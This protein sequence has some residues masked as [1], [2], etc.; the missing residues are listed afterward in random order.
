MATFSDNFSEQLSCPLCLNRFDDPKVLPCLHTFCRRCLEELMRRERATC[1]RCPTCKHEV[2][3]SHDT[4]IDC[5]PS[6]FFI[7]NILDVVV[8]HD[9]D[10]DNGVLDKHP[11]RRRLCTSCDEGSE[12][13]SRCQDCNEYLCDNCVRAHQRV[14]LT[15]DHFIVRLAFDSPKPLPSPSPIQPV[16]DRPPSYCETH[17]KEI[18]RLY[19]DTCSK[20]ICRECTM[21][22]HIGHS[23]IY[24]QDAVESAKTV[25]LKLLADARAGMKA[26]EESIQVRHVQD[27]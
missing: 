6:N 14:R 4:G 23:F 3:L 13:S 10:Y 9:D 12:A 15:K 5:L 21:V 16:S 20:A 8:S 26:I 1:L 7:N 19:C 11:A 24:L 18:L 2:P 17:E 25:T 22:E 27:Y